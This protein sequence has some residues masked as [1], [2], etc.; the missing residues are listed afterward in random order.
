MKGSLQHLIFYDGQCGLCDGVVQLVL[1]IDGKKQFVFAPLQGKTAAYY[2]KELAENDKH[3]D[4]VILVQ[5][6]LST[7]RQLFIYSRAVFR[8]FWLLGGVWSL[9]GWLSF[10][11]T[12]LFDWAYRLIARYRYRLFGQQCLIPPKDQQDRFLP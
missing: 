7:D 6:Y 3:I 4:S 2:L 5:N 10:L 9:L 8:I 12:V 1:K 11:P